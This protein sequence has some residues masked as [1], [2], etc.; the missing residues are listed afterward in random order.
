MQTGKRQV[1]YIYIKAFCKNPSG[2]V[3][4]SNELQWRYRSQGRDHIKCLLMKERFDTR[5]EEVGLAHR[6]QDEYSHLDIC[7]NPSMQIPSLALTIQ[8]GKKALVHLFILGKSWGLHAEI[9]NSSIIRLQDVFSLVFL[10]HKTRLTHRVNA[11]KKNI[12]ILALVHKQ[13]VLFYRRRS[14]Y[15]KITNQ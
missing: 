7:S 2:A 3:W 5:W 1:D 4:P 10:L 13:L 14:K 11:I 15:L 12:R 9:Y 8:K 6:F